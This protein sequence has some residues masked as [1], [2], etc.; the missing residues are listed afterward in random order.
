MRNVR[1]KWRRFITSRDGRF[2]VLLF[3]L[4]VVLYLPGI[5][6]GLP[7]AVTPDRINPWGVDELAPLGPAAELYSVFVAPDPTFNPQYPLF[8]YLV[9]A[10][11]VGPY[12]AFLWLTG[13][14]A[15]PSPLYPFGLTDPI[16][17]LRATTLLTRLV[18]VLMGAGTV[19]VGYKTA[20]F[21]WSRTA[22]I[23]AGF[24]VLLLYPMFYYARTSNVDVPALFWASLGFLVFVIGFRDGLTTTRAI[25][26]GALAALATAT[27]DASYAAFLPLG[28]VLA[29]SHLRGQ[30]RQGATWWQSARH[31]LFA[32]MSGLLVYLVASGLVFSPAR[33][34]QHLEFVTQGSG[35]SDSSGVF[36]YSTPATLT[37]Y[38]TILRRVVV[39]LDHSMGLPILLA[40]PVGV[41]LS[42]RHARSN[43][44]LLVAALGI[45]G[46]VI[47][48]VRFVLL[49]FVLIIAYIL[50][51]YAAYGLASLVQFS[52][53]RARQVA[54]AGVVLA[55]G[56]ALLRGGDLTYQMLRDSRYEL[57]QWLQQNAKAEHTVGYYGARQKLP[58][59]DGAITTLPMAGRSGAHD[60]ATAVDPE[61]VLII[62]QFSFEPV[63]EWELAEEKYQALLRG[64]MGYERVLV[65]Q[66]KS[67]FQK[68]PITFVNPPVQVFVRQDLVSS[69]SAQ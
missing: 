47:L 69:L 27:K 67:L 31:L 8:H 1:D 43:L 48:P 45:L 28:L 64:D 4:A 59:L 52:R 56:W 5:G 61:F 23:I 44:A 33:F 68:R 2:M 35:A 29:A 14:L 60:G 20:V 25:L 40:A 10:I 58:P 65:L 49:R 42:W 32:F 24:L 12:L 53:Q 54:L 34:Q 38:L 66:T 63:H 13:G 7:Y 30:R 22:G 21:L 46:L 39:H 50:A 18:S 11:L 36:Y 26:L 9:Q 51:L 15:S 62:P 17:S 37:G 16:S 57:A 6:W 41:F 3:L 55:C 19:V